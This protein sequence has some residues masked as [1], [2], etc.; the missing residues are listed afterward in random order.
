MNSLI[1]NRQKWITFVTHVI[2]IT[3]LFILPELMQNYN[4]PAWR[5]MPVEAIYL[6]AA[7][8]ICIFYFCYYFVLDHTLMSK[9]GRVLKFVVSVIALLVV[10]LVLIYLIQ[11][12]VIGFS[13]PRHMPPSHD[14]EVP[15]GFDTFSIM[16]RYWSFFVRD[17]GMI[18]LTIGLS[19]ALK[20]G[21]NW[22]DME[23][24]H[25]HMLSIQK[26]EELNNLKSQINPHFL[27]NTLNTIYALIAVSPAQAQEAVHQLSTLLR[28]VLYENPQKVAISQEINFIKSYISLMEM[29]LGEGIVKV[30]Y[31]DADK[32]DAELPPLIFVTLIENA[33]KHGNTGRKDQPIEISITVDDQG[34]IV[35]RTSNHFLSKPSANNGAGGIGIANL[36][37][38][39]QLIYGD[40]ARLETTVNGDVYNAMLT[41]NKG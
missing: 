15:Q 36:K 17:A 38:R 9:K 39:L 28:Y 3:I 21:A 22:A 26:D 25:Q 23:R 32:M 19:V 5:S 29:R 8:Y 35:C 16:V 2:V 18:L 10:G 41:I 24:K 1:A 34:D 6:K 14:G 33:F 40:R 27:F 37:R 30:Q 31:P 12:F 7:V 4:R 20:L 13:M 11:Y